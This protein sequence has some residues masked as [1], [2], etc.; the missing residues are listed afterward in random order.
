MDK[1]PGALGALMHGLPASLAVRVLI[2]M[3]SRTQRPAATPEQQQAMSRARRL[4]YGARQANTAWAW[5]DDGPTVILVHGWNGS[6]VQLAPLA[7]R[8]AA[9]GLRC[10]AID[11]TGHGAS[12]GHRTSWH[13][14]VDDIAHASASLAGGKAAAVIGHSAGGLA[15][16]AARSV[17]GLAAECWACICAPSHPFPPIR[18]VQQRLNPPAQVLDRYRA[19][20]AS[21][22]GVSW[23]ALE[24]GA[25]FRDPPERLQ[26]VYDPHDRFVDHTEG[27]RVH[28]WC[29][30]A[31]L[32]KTAGHGH[33]KVLASAELVDVLGRFLGV[34]G[35]DSMPLPSRAVA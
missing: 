7:Q 13:A 8:L 29:P 6:A 18:A 9:L 4:R 31:E 1:K 19:H 33:A 23:A 32:V 3:A 14:F 30:K 15:A 25:A 17:H 11:V 12:A 27:D 22:F 35:S 24:D 5:G 2:R 28:A 10:I 34:Q 21:A 26:L 20:I 16:M